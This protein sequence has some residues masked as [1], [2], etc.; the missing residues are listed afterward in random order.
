MRITKAIFIRLGEAGIWEKDSIENNKI[1]FGW[2]YIPLDLIRNNNWKKIRQL[3]EENF[4]SRDKKSGATSNFNALKNICDANETTA[5]IT[6]HS[7]KLYWCIPE[8]GSVKEDK[9]SK[10]IDTKIHWSAKSVKNELN[11][12]IFELIH[13]SG[14]L[15][16]YQGFRGTVC[17]VGNKLKQ[18]DYLRAIINGSESEEYSKL[19][20]ARQEMKLALIPAIKNLTPKDFET[21]IDLIFRN[22]G[23]K[24]MSVLG[25]VMQF[26]DIVLEEP[27]TKKLHG[28]QI[29]TKS[30]FAEYKR[31]AET[32]LGDY[33]ENFDS[34]FYVVHTPDKK[35]ENHTEENANIRLLHVSE[36]AD[37]AIE[38][39]LISWIMDKSS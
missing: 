27:L 24:R 11:T 8:A 32:Y 29:K 3:V 23:W 16:S 36:I 26:V 22:G 38:S 10:Y 9:I 2:N 6:F 28:V 15:T 4:T 34:F 30:S 21:V 35:L 19:Y 7:G 13:L 12:R 25:E 5:L 1:R 17:A 31:Y 33:Q 20:E 18:F 39:G 14:R 37:L